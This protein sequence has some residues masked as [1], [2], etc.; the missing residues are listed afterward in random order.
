MRRFVGLTAL[1]LFVVIYVA[2]A[3]VV[4]ANHILQLPGAVQIAYFAIAGLAWTIPAM[5]IIKWMRKVPKSG[6]TA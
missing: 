3:M 1:V 4:G 6:S 5:G 2:I